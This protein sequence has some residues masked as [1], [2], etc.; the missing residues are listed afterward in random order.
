MPDSRPGS[1]PTGL[2]VLRGGAPPVVIPLT[3]ERYLLG[4]ADAADVVFED[5]C[6][7][8]LHGVVRREGGRWLF[9]DLGSRFCTVLL[10]AGQ[11][12]QPLQAKETVELSVHDVLDLGGGEAR[13]ELLAGSVRPELD[14]DADTTLLSSAAK[15]FAKK[16]KVAALT[17]APIFLL[18]P[19]GAGKTFAARR[20]HELSRADGPFVPINCARLPEQATALHSELLGHVK[21]AF[22]GADR[23]RTGKLFQ[24]DGGTLFLDEVESLSDMAQGFLLDVLEGSGDLAPLGAQRVDM[25]APVVRLISAS[26]VPLAKSDLRRDLA[27]RLAEGY[28]WAMPT[29]EE[30]RTDIPGLIQFFVEE[31]IGMLGV[32]LGVTEET[33]AFAK[34]AAWPGQ[35]RQLR[36]TIIA[37]AQQAVANKFAEGKSPDKVWLRRRDI[38]QHL[39][40]RQVAFDGEIPTESPSPVTGWEVSDVT[41]RPGPDDEARLQSAV[42]VDVPPSVNPRRL[43]RDQIVA[44][45][46]ETGGNQSAAARRLGIARNTL[47]TKIKAFNIDVGDVRSS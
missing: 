41:R 32:D 21:G 28:M 44:I 22:T 10:R 33:L 5:S 20:I 47:G 39:R 27:E 35:I 2:R 13:V 3:E 9:E 46:E 45:L 26:K 8:R 15:A 18:G 29:L 12:P 42:S 30:R 19:S 7:S 6:V 25:R 40:E 16:L 14:D 11:Q 38:E 36:A 37:L 4:R 43:T 24:A 31:Q 17:R 34:Q 23:A 1:Q